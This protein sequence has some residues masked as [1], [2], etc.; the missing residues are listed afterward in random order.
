MCG[1]YISQPI[2]NFQSEQVDGVA[3]CYL[4]YYYYLY[5][6]QNLYTN[7]CRFGQPIF[8]L[9]P[10]LAGNKQFR[11]WKALKLQSAIYRAPLLHPFRIIPSARSDDVSPAVG[12]PRFTRQLRNGS[13][14][15][16]MC[17]KM[18]RDFSFAA[19]IG[20]GNSTCNHEFQHWK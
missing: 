14:R 7:L 19:A 2:F 18:K 20:D 4:G 5:P 11:K 17:E 10:T 16:I 8:P 1:S 13:V 3:Q 9:C 15:V 12:G 6:I